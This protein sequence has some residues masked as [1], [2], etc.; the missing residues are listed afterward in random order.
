[1]KLLRV[2]QEQEFE[3]LRQPSRRIDVLAMTA[4]H[5]RFAGTVEQNRF[6]PRPLPAACR[7]HSVPAL[8]GDA[9]DIAPLVIR[10]NGDLFA[11]YRWQLAETMKTFEYALAGELSPSQNLVSAL[12][13]ARATAGRS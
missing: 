3:R 12:M 7:T 10:Y 13:I 4:T 9:R 2:L 11:A 5:R 8:R 1:M 6:R